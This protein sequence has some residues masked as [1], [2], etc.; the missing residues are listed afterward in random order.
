M[1]RTERAALP[2]ANFTE[3]RVRE[4]QW[5]NKAN[6]L[7]QQSFKSCFQPKQRGRY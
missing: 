2:V 5:S 6:G 4:W 7:F 1:C 3:L